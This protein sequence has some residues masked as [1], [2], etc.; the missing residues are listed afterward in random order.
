MERKIWEFSFLKYILDFWFFLFG[1]V[2]DGINYICSVLRLYWYTSIGISRNRFYLKLS[3]SC[4]ADALYTQLSSSGGSSSTESHTPNVFCRQHKNSSPLWLQ[5]ICCWCFFSGLFLSCLLLLLSS[6][7]GVFRSSFLSILLLH[8]IVKSIA[9]ASL[10][11]LHSHTHT[12]TQGTHAPHTLEYIIFNFFFYFREKASESERWY[13]Q[14][15]SPPC[16]VKSI[17]VHSTEHSHTKFALNGS[18]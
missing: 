8:T 18:T 11:K 1:L 6:R 4:V 9:F 3:C 17:S 10:N 15:H 5:F 13:M 14:N 16:A 2:G 7:F 12:H